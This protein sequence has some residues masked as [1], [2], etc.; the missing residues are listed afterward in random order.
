MQ[1]P[2]LSKSAERVTGWITARL[3]RPG[4]RWLYRDRVVKLDEH[5]L[6]IR[7]YY[8]PF[9]SK[10]IVYSAIEGLERRPLKAWQ[11]QFRVQGMDLQRR[12]YSRD[13]HRGE[14]ESAIDLDVGSLFRPVLTPEDPDLVVRILEQRMAA[15][16]LEVSAGTVGR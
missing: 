9:G 6:T 3:P 16:A 13:R 15:A 7:S 4:R 1:L 2:N 14:K 12:W 5:A 10:R 8:W 11:G